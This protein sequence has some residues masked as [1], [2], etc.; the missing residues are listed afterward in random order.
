MCSSVVAI[1]VL[2]CN[3]AMRVYFGDRVMEDVVL[4]F[5]ECI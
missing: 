1:L 4:N 5:L 2:L 3:V